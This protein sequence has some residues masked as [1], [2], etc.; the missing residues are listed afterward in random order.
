MAEILKQWKSYNI[1]LDM[2]TIFIVQ[3]LVEGYTFKSAHRRPYSIVRTLSQHDCCWKHFFFVISTK[4][5]TI[6]SMYVLSKIIFFKFYTFISRLI[7]ILYKQRMSGVSIYLYTICE[8]DLD[9]SIGLNHE[10]TMVYLTYY[11]LSKPY[12]KI[13]TLI[14]QLLALHTDPILHSCWKAKFS[15]KSAITYYR[16]SI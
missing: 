4:Q 1:S 2:V 6:S 5:I 7:L 13:G 9:G 14:P 3:V 10:C 8:G 16:F 11:C 15:F 12:S